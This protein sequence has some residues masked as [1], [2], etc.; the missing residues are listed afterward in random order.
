MFG[1]LDRGFCV[2]V[3]LFKIAS[4]YLPDAIVWASAAVICRNNPFSEE[5]LGSFI[6]EGFIR[7]RLIGKSAKSWHFA[8]ISSEEGVVGQW[9]LKPIT[10]PEV[11]A[12]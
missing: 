8:L 10:H 3:G 9:A 7:V 11:Q 5:M 6:V 2:C 12:A 4:H 1:L